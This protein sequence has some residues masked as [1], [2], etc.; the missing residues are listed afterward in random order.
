MN[1]MQKLIIIN[2]TEEETKE[3]KEN[4][5]IEFSEQ[6]YDPEN[7]ETLMTLDG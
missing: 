7:D 5:G 2:N 1:K 4:V 3:E 6:K